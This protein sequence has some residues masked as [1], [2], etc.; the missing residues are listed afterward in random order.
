MNLPLHLLKSL[1]PHLASCFDNLI[2]ST[3]THRKMASG[4]RKDRRF[5]FHQRLRR[6][7]KVDVK[8]DGGAIQGGGK[9]VGVNV[10]LA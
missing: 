6:V 4:T 9:A 8:L 5:I 3:Q 2:K 1:T 10:V 7:G